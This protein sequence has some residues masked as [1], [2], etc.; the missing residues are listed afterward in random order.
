MGAV[1]AAQDLRIGREVAVKR[2]TATTPE[3]E[4]VARFLREARTQARLQHPAIV[5]VHE[6]GIDDQDR[7]FFTMKRITGQTLSQRLAEGATQNRLLRVFVDVCR[8]IEFAHAR[9][10]VHRDLKPSN[11]MIGDYGET[12]VIDWGIARVIADDG[13][14]PALY[15]DAAMLGGDATKSGTVLGTP[16]YMAPEQ[17]RGQ[18]ATPAA[19][20][21]A[22]GSILFEL[23]TGE[24][25][26]AR[27]STAMATTLS[28]PQVR[29]S[30]RYP[31]KPIPP[32]LDN[33][34]FEALA[35]VPD[36]RPSA[37]DLAEKVQAYLDGDRDLA[38]RRELAAIQLAAARDGLANDEPDAR[39]SAIRRAGRAIALDP[40]S[41]EAAELLSALL[42]EPPPENRMPADLGR[43]LEEQE[44][45][46]N[47]DRSRRGV[48]AYLSVFTV[49]P[50]LLAM[51]VKNWGIL[52]ALYG[53]ML[54]GSLSAVRSVRRGQPSV[55]VALIVNFATALMFTRIA[56]PFV[57][58]PL[59][60]C[61]TLV[62]LT[63]IPWLNQR[64]W[65][66]MIWMVATVM[67]PIVFEWVGFLPATWRIGDGHMIVI[68]DLV[69]THGRFDELALVIGNLVF[70]GVVAWFLIVINRSRRISQ[71]RLFILAWHLRQLLP[72]T[73]RW[74]PWSRGEPHA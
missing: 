47:R 69:R 51:D 13:D 27:G 49:L 29:P 46:L 6:L 40:E 32:E 19:D 3:R 1:T 71:R 53:L 61:C 45:E 68:S 44:R 50:V 33:L 42:L 20:V 60:V 35:E 23:L 62:A 5:P 41:E 59:L 67:I 36:Q 8:A 25:L 66:V 21:Y 11:I 74:W 34:C 52:V 26:H 12:Y 48:W 30:G 37:H 22:L 55:T 15:G 17:V 16:G 72:Q 4:Q 54:L 10:V 9:G 58:T 56:G 63:P 64:P 14:L 24:S 73:K 38:R 31:E 39:A 43:G 57:L 65:V 70:T 18:P 28:T 7:L 2:M